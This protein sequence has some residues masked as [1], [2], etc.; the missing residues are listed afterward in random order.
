MWSRKTYAGTGWRHPCSG[1]RWSRSCTHLSALT[2]H[3][4]T[5]LGGHLHND[6]RAALV[7]SETS[8][9]DTV[10]V[11]DGLDERGLT[12]D[13]DQLLAGVPVL[14][15][16]ADVARGHGL[17]EGDVDGQVDATEP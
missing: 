1:C 2:L 17:V 8:N 16:L 13:L 4:H 9:L 3:L 14:V 6:T 11:L 7:N 5:I 15:D 12:D 10:L